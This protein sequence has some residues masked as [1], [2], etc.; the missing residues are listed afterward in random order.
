MKTATIE[1]YH[2]RGTSNHEFHILY[3]GQHIGGNRAYFP[4][5]L[6]CLTM[7]MIF[8][9]NRGFTH[10]KLSDPANRYSLKGGAL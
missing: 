5:T 7:A 4:D 2:V 3:R 10:W 9:K 6:Q 8:A 1:R